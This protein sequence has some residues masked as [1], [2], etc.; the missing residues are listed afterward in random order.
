MKNLQK[1]PKNWASDPVCKKSAPQTGDIWENDFLFEQYPD[2]I[3]IVDN[4]GN[5]AGVNKH[6]SEMF[7]YEKHEMLGNTIEMLL[8][9]GHRRSH[10]KKRNNYINT[11]ASD[12]GRPMETGTKFQAQRKDGSCFPIDI[13]LSPSVDKSVTITVIR[14]ISEKIARQENERKA[15]E[16]LKAVFDAAPVA[17]FSVSRDKQIMSWSRAAE[18]LFGYRADEV[19]NKAYKDF[20][21]IVGKSDICLK[22][23]ND[24]MSGQTVKDVHRKRRH[25]DGQL[26]DVSID[27]APMYD[28]EGKIFSITY[29]AQDISERIKAEE[30]ERKTND[31]LKA[32]VDSAPVAIFVLD[33][34]MK[35]LSWSREAEQLFGFKAGEVLGK[36][37]L[38][39]PPDEGAHSSE[40]SHTL[41]SVFEGKT[42]RDIQ[43]RRMKK[44]G[45][46]VGV[47]ISA[48]PIF[49]PNGEIESAAYCAQDITERLRSEEKLHH[50]AFRD[51][52]TDL[53]NRECLKKTINELFADSDP[54]TDEILF[55]AKFRIKGFLEISNTLGQDSVEELICK[56]S[57]RMVK[58]APDN[59]RIYRT[60]RYDFALAMC[61][62]GCPLE[63]IDVIKPILAHM[64]RK[65]EIDTQPVHL[66]VDA[67]FAISPGHGNVA[68]EFLANANL[69]LS[70]ATI[71]PGRNV[72]LFDMTMK[73]KIQAKRQLD[74]DLRHAFKENEFELFYQPQIRLS[75][76]KLVGAEALLRWRRP[77]QVLVQPAA[78]IEALANSPI[79]YDMGNWIMRTAIGQTVKWQEQ[80]L[81]DLRIG[82]NLFAAQF[83]HGTLAEDVDKALKL[84]NFDANLLELEITENIAI[85]LK[86]SII[87]PLQIVRNKGVG[88]AFDDFGTGY[89]A[90]S[91]LVN[92]PLSRIK[93]DK[94]FLEHIPDSE[95][96]AAIV[97]AIISMAHGLGL[98]VIAEGVETKAH[99]EF[100][101][102]EKCEEVQ[103]FYYAK[104]LPADEFYKFGMDVNAKYSNLIC[105]DIAGAA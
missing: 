63:I 76:N 41:N 22:L 101:T 89:A 17:I 86:R 15:K 21:Y 35:V 72:R 92:Y 81:V 105:H 82:V 10:V 65:F 53:P 75:D 19:I 62:V 77:G 80:G 5:I 13:M 33:R 83:E 44:D 45:S 103:G 85:G 51:Q 16:A 8:P 91:Y 25:R 32:I 93:I 6:L 40:C 56:L 23:F 18:R 67:G 50:L 95:E 2:A 39:I 79:A 70:A 20:P 42:I 43:R 87:E 59:A 34:E 38:L 36:P 66:E 99:E 57:K 96:E 11:A 29:S 58:H 37:Y 90:L 28:D 9:K 84:H 24:A 14:D 54:E 94:S 26:F 4:K 61:G 69:A 27:T 31:T 47:S 97:N 1:N 68:D 88:I 71:D 7:G 98:E 3:L 12:A 74:I 46:L 60:A 104:P 49:Q 55:V 30:R 102:Q 100:L 78:F 73:S 64:T 52:L 48:A